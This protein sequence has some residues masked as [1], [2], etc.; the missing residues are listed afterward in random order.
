ML[1]AIV[2]E[3]IHSISRSKHDTN[4]NGLCFTLGNIF[5]CTVSLLLFNMNPR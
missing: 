1:S 4:R 5:R 3:I 2:L